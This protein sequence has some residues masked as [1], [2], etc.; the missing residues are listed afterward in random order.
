MATASFGGGSGPAAPTQDLGGYIR[1][2]DW[3]N[4]D[5]AAASLNAFM[6]QNGYN[7]NDVA[8]TMNLDQGVVAQGARDHGYNDIIPDAGTW[9]GGGLGLATGTSNP[10]AY[11]NSATPEYLAANGVTMGANNPNQPSRQVETISYAPPGIPTGSPQPQ[12]GLASFGGTPTGTSQGALTTLA[13]PATAPASNPFGYSD[14]QMT[15]IRGAWNDFH[16]GKRNAGSIQ[17]DMS[18]Y[19]VSAEQI[20]AVMGIPVSQVQSMLSAGYGSGT[21]T[22]YTGQ[23]LTQAPQ[24]Q[25]R[26][27]SN[28]LPAPTPYEYN[29]AQG[30]VPSYFPAS[31]WKNA[32]GA[33]GGMNVPGY[34]D[35]GAVVYNPARVDEIYNQLKDL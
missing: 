22:P 24:Y 4:G 1:S 5:A 15:N 18:R 16:S 2:L 28:F 14:E 32:K 19:G 31:Y 7:T 27:P 33:Y 3:G 25:P 23:T 26:T 11:A 9:N 29:S 35:G 8:N 34:A 12:G 17:S 20:A 30:K 21:S 10:N 13:A 6:T